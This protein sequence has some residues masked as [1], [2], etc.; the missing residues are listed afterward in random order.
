MF[1]QITINGCEEFLQVYEAFRASVAK[2]NAQEDPMERLR[3]ARLAV[4]VD[5]LF[6][7]FS[8]EQKDQLTELLIIKKMIPEEVRKSLKAFGGQ[9]V[10]T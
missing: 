1:E 8:P 3:H 9:V 4:K 10:L 5:K 7:N 2:L 6:N